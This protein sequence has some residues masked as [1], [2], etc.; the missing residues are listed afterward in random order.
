VEILKLGNIAVKSGKVSL[1]SRIC[2]RRL[3]GG[4]SISLCFSEY[5]LSQ[6]LV[7]SGRGEVTV[8][9]IQRKPKDG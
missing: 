6:E 1:D 9:S 8:K 2:F 5:L 7:S 4:S 3:Y